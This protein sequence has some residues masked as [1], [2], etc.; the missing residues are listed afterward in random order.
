MHLHNLKEIQRR[1]KI[2]KQETANNIQRLVSELNKAV[3]DAELV[4]L[5]V[6]FFDNKHSLDKT[7][8][9]IEAGIYEQ[10]KY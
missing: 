10:I 8:K 6:D 2:S 5:T 3:S 7:D 9:R 1:E 4:G